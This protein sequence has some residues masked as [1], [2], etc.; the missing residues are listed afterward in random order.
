[1]ENAFYYEN[2]YYLIP[3]EFS[4][5]EELADT[6]RKG[7][8]PIAFQTIA[9]LEDHRV[10]Y[11][12]VTKG[13]SMAPYFLS[14]YHDTPTTLVI[15]N[16]DEIYPTH[17]DV[18]SQEEYNAKLREKILEICP[19]CLRYK[20][21][22]NRVQSLNGHFEEMGLDGVCLFR[23]ETKPSPRS[24]RVHLLYFG[25]YYMRSSRFGSSI[26]EMLGDLKER[27][28]ARYSGAELHEENGCRKLILSCKKKELLLPVVTDAISKYLYDIS[29]G[30]FMIQLSESACNIKELID[31]FDAAK[32][33]ELFRK[34]C[35]K[36]GVSIGILEY[37]AESA[38]IV[39]KSLKPMIDHFWL[40][41]LCL[42]NGKEYYLLSDTADVLK[43]LR[44][45][46]PLLQT[47]DAKINVYSQ[48]GN[49]RYDISFDM[50]SSEL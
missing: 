45:R 27:F 36:Y 5:F 16:A 13:R 1:M 14:G 47:Y 38:E 11:I 39:R 26:D 31:N 35:K 15:S 23:Q 6:V 24:F 20:P 40:F 19:G 28:Y 33:N 9:L 49:K 25:G 42:E 30:K 43:E 32:N 8:L 2:N 10:N 46:T 7:P 12:Y 29:C 37:Q 21:L 4:D 48:Y 17:V 44:F 18:Y 22:S 50:S 34:E 3:K 41:P